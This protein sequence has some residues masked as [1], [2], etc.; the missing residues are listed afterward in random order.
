[1]L[2]GH[3]SAM[4]RCVPEMRPERALAVSTHDEVTG[5]IEE[6]EA[7]AQ[8]LQELAALLRASLKEDGS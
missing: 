1:V 7:A 5:W 3:C 6:Y 2:V 8:T 4:H